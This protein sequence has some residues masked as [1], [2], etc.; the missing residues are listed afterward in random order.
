MVDLINDI[1][2]AVKFTEI[3]IL[4]LCKRLFF[5]LGKAQVF[6]VTGHNMYNL[7]LSSS[8]KICTATHTEH[9]NDKTNGVKGE[10]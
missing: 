1:C 5:V 9:T 6:G 8:G 4:W 2:I 10:Q 7:P 3:T